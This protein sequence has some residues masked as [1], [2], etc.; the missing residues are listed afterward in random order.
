MAKLYRFKVII[1]N[2]NRQTTSV[3]TTT[4]RVQTKIGKYCLMFVRQR[5]FK[6]W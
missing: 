6:T 5:D 4:I 3:S 1:E 2:K